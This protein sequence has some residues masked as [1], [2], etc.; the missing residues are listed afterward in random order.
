M[1]KQL[2]L[3]LEKT[4][5]G[6]DTENIDTVFS[7]VIVFLK[8]WLIVYGIIFLTLFVLGIS[9]ANKVN[10]LSFVNPTAY[11]VLTGIFTVI[12]LALFLTLYIYIRKKKT[13]ITVNE[14]KKGYRFYH[15]IDYFN[16]VAATI[17]FLYFMVMFIVTPAQVT[18]SSME[19]TYENGDRILVWHLFYEPKNDDVVIIDAE[20]RIKNDEETNFIIKRVVATGGDRVAYVDGKLFVNGN[21]IENI[22]IDEYTKLVTDVIENVCY[23]TGNETIVPDG[24]VIVLGDNRRI[25]YDSRSFGLINEKDILG[26]S[27][28]R[29]YP[30]NKIGIAKKDHK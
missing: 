29:I 1:K 30:F 9:L 11:L 10:K 18:G 7:K 21:Y 26:K 28:L 4:I 20:G 8:K 3:E 14:I 13:A 23:K 17:S 27:F 22:T 16:F 25:S 6:E 15:I 19:S 5:N 24:F 2:L 12:C